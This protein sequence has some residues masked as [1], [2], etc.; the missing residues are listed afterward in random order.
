MLK[1]TAIPNTFRSTP[2]VYAAAKEYQIFVPVT[3][4]CVMWIAVDGYTEGEFYDD[5]NGVLRSDVDVHRI[6]VPMEVLDAGRGYTVHFRRVIERRPYSSVV[7]DVCSTHFPFRPVPDG[8]VNIYHIADAHNHIDAPI[9]CGRYFGEELDLL[10]LNGDIPNH[11]GEKLG[12]EAIITI[13]SQLTQGEIP[14][15]FARGNHDTRG[16]FAEHLFEVAPSVNGR[17]YYTVRLG[18]MWFLVLDCGED[19]DDSNH[20]YGH[21]NCFHNFRLQETKFIEDVIARADEEYNAP[22]VKHRFVLCHTPFAYTKDA[23]FNIEIELYTYWS[24]IIKENIHPEMML[25]G[26]LHRTLLCPIGGELDHKGQPCTLVLA[27]QCIKKDDSFAV[28]GALTVT[29]EA[30]DIVFNAN[31]GEIVG[32]ERI[33][34]N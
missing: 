11:A 9:A 27:S 23:P 16:A 5:C 14:V 34:L 22:G 3:E 26:P 15:V 18:D 25:C 31:S 19:K 2:I 33:E 28:G 17:S 1:N 4:P 6:V 10:I 20:Q 21:C 30:I 7:D 29:P 32:Q 24:R 8:K 13:A 12:L